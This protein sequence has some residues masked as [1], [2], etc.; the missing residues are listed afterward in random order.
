MSYILGIDQGG[1]KT[2]AAIMCEDGTIVGTAVVKGVYFPK[3]GVSQATDR[4]EEAVNLAREQAGI[5]M[6]DIVITVAGITGVDWPGDDK[7]MEDALRERMKLERIVVCNDMVNALYTV[8]GISHGMV[9]GVGTGMNG[10]IMDETG[11]QFVYGDYME[12]SMQGGSAL[13]VRAIR[14]VFDA[15]MGLCGSTAL[16]GLF[17]EHAG[18][19]TV[20]ELLHVFMTKQGFFDEIR[21]LMPEI[22]KIAAQGDKE[23]RGMLE[24]FAERTV[25]FIFAGF[26]K[27]EIMPKQE[28]I[29]L[30]G[31]VVKGED[32]YLTGQIHKKIKEREPEAQI[33]L[34]EYEPVV[35]ACVMGLRLLHIGG[36]EVDRNVA[37]SAG[38]KGLTIFDSKE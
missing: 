19:D 23:T 36:E 18:V 9:L 32:N 10:A 6:K 2:A 38:E 28:K 30:A 22:L 24:E 20:D 8:A 16:T 34:A 14:K 33:V 3:H 13:A 4:I 5:E 37:V 31:S 27:M 15:E 11:R 25:E 35:G 21:F 26:R 7:I 29:V 17:L 1:S 12:D